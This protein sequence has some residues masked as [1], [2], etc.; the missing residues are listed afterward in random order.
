MKTALVILCKNQEKYAQVIVRGILGQSV[1]PDRVLVVMDRPGLLERT[2]T[3]KAY[4]EIPGCEFLVVSS[5]PDRIARPPM[6][7]GV[8]PFCAGHCRNLALEMLYD[9]DMAVFIDGDCIPMS[10]M[11]ESHVAAYEDGC[12]TVG[13]RTEI[14]W[15][16][17]DQRQ[18]SGEHPIPIFGKTPNYV[19]SER[20]I[21]DS[22]VVW[23]CNFGITAG[24]VKAIQKLN[25]ELYGVST[26]FHPDFTGRWGGEDGF[27]GIEC[28]YGGIPIRTTPVTGDDGVSHIEHPRPSNR[29]NHRAFVAFLETK[30]RELLFLLNAT[31]KSDREFVPLDQLMRQEQ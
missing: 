6:M 29:Y 15:N 4:G 20:Y 1:K 8:V 23:T 31:G 3:R 27:L 26:V 11:L 2:A 19:T 25:G 5:L 24:A 28:F 21:A 14:K 9:I 30:R 12:I 13:R 10:G 7:E 17:D 18:C 22:G 16:S